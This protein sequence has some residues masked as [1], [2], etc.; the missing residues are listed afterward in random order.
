MMKH[1]KSRLNV[2][3]NILYVFKEIFHPEINIPSL[4]T[5]KYDFLSSVEHKRG[6]FEEYIHYQ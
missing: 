2:V 1:E 4:F 5:S 3:S 6:I